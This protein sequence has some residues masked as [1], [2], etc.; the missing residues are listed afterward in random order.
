MAGDTAVKSKNKRPGDGSVNKYSKPSKKVKPELSREEKLQKKWRSLKDQVNEGFL[1]NA[2]KT[3]RRSEWTFIPT[4]LLFRTYFALADFV[5]PALT[6]LELDPDSPSAIRTHIQILLSL[7][8]YKDALAFITS[9]QSSSSEEDS[10]HPWQLEQAY[11]LYKLGRVPEAASIVEAIRAE[12]MQL[13]EEA[14]DARALDVLDAQIVGTTI[15][16]RRIYYSCNEYLLT[17]LFRVG[18]NTASRTSSKLSNYTRI[19]W[20]Q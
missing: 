8:R 13:E 4:A 19:Y 10:Q 7:D 20:R 3:S 1:D 11:A 5:H 6:V 18:R 16:L 9:R 15:T 17:A 2:Y 14:D 12:S